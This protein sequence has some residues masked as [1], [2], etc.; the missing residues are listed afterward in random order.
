MIYDRVGPD[1]KRII[2][3]ILLGKAQLDKVFKK[4]YINCL[5]DGLSIMFDFVDLVTTSKAKVCLVE[6]RSIEE[7]SSVDDYYGSVVNAIRRQSGE[8]PY[9]ANY[10]NKFVRLLTQTVEMDGFENDLENYLEKAL[11]FILN[12]DDYYDSVVQIYSKNEENDFEESEEN[13]V[14]MNSEYSPDQQEYT[15]LVSQT[16]GSIDYSLE[17]VSR[18]ITGGGV[19]RSKVRED[20]QDVVFRSGCLADAVSIMVDYVDLVTKGSSKSCHVECRGVDARTEC[21]EYFVDMARTVLNESAVDN[22]LDGLV[23]TFINLLRENIAELDLSDT[24]NDHDSLGNQIQTALDFILSSSD[25]LDSVTTLFSAQ[26]SSIELTDGQ[27]AP[28]SSHSEYIPSVVISARSPRIVFKNDPSTIVPRS[29]RR[30]SLFQDE[31]TEFTQPSSA[32][33]EYVRKASDVKAF[34]PRFDIQRLPINPVCRG[35]VPFSDLKHLTLEGHFGYSSV[36]SAQLLHGESLQDVTVK[37][38]TEKAEALN[39][40]GGAEVLVT[41]LLWEVALL[42][43]M[44]HPHIITC[45]GSGGVPRLGLRAPFV[46]LERLQEHSLAE[47]LHQFVSSAPR[48]AFLPYAAV[49]QAGKSMAAALLYLHQELHA[50]ARVIY[51]NLCTES[52]GFAEN[53]ALKLTDFGAAACVPKSP[54]N[55][56]YLLSGCCYQRYAAPEVLHSQSYSPSSDVYG[57]GVVMWQIATGQTPFQEIKNDSFKETVVANKYRPPLTAVPKGLAE[58]ISKCWS[59]DPASRP[60]AAAL[61]SEMTSLLG[62]LSE[63]VSPLRPSPVQLNPLNQQSKSLISSISSFGKAMAR[64]FSA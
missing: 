60:S 28:P 41:Q 23:R 61:V 62:S 13:D 51:C 42:E 57:F 53:G 48:P 31:Q 15:K 14:H 9:I 25:Y 18:Y 20:D 7:H 55:A 30:Q 33:N 50:E 29:P 26:Q 63:T 39:E 2:R 24:E 43:R 35:N 16:T 27:T 1:E 22:V 64:K 36:F 49:L 59:H 6:C 8:D 56:S 34:S 19:A 52:V 12:S 47:M 58:V 21:R 11:E 40:G 45:Y 5:A 44:G 17:L 37:T 10:M 32:A 54:V 3:Y 46:L 4:N 38:L